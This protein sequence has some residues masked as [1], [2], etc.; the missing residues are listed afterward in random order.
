V[1][2]IGPAAVGTEAEWC[3]RARPFGWRNW[4]FECDPSGGW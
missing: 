2:K 1:L 4:I 3:C